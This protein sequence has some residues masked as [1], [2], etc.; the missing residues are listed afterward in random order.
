MRSTGNEVLEVR[1]HVDDRRARPLGCCDAFLGAFSVLSSSVT[2]GVMTSAN[3]LEQ[4]SRRAARRRSP[5]RS[6]VDLV[7][8]HR[9]CRART[10]CRRSAE[11]KKKKKKKKKKRARGRPRCPCVTASAPLGRANAAGRRGVTDETAVRAAESITEA[12]NAAARLL[13]GGRLGLEEHEIDGRASIDQRAGSSHVLG[14][15]PTRDEARELAEVHDGH[16]GASLELGD[17]GRGCSSIPRER[18]RRSGRAG[19][20]MSRPCATT[21]PSSVDDAA[22]ELG[23]RWPPCRGGTRPFASSRR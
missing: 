11:Q 15:D 21:L 13:L 7:A 3:D 8:R 10:P 23:G 2:T 6:K 14:A 17:G 4:R 19:S 12:S 5:C 20:S 9:L 18:A 1:V 16:A 22:R